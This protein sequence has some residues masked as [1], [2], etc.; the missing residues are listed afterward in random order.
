MKSPLCHPY[1]SPLLLLL[2]M[3]GNSLTRIEMSS[4]HTHTHMK[5]LP[6]PFRF[7]SLCPS[8]SSMSIKARTTHTTHT[9]THIMT[10]SCITHFVS[11][12]HT[13]PKSRGSAHHVRNPFN[14]TTC[15]FHSYS[16]CVCVCVCVTLTLC[17]QKMCLTYSTRVSGQMYN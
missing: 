5:R 13:L 17:V 11:L 6:A 7:A 3:H 2:S 16:V 10:T 4:S 1:L 14:F 12:T 8:R 15:L 9:H